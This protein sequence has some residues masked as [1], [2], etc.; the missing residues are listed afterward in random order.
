MV[1]ALA[2]LALLGLVV[3][4]PT[5]TSRLIPEAPAAVPGAPD[6]AAPEAPAPAESAPLAPAEGQPATLAPQ[7]ATPA[8]PQASAMQQA[9]AALPLLLGVFWLLSAWLVD[10]EARRA[11]VVQEPWGDRRTA[12]YS[13][14]AI[15]CVFPLILAGLI[16]GAWGFVSFVLFVANRQN[17]VAGIQAGAL[18]LL[19]GAALLVVRSL[20]ARWQAGRNARGASRMMSEKRKPRSAG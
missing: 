18:I 1:A 10:A 9:L 12:A 13:C 5:I 8:G 11:F 2:L 14:L 15:G 17:W 20:A 4:G 6:A 7:T 3:A 19:A 16:F